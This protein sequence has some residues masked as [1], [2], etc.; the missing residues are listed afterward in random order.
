M[1]D[2]H[3]ETFRDGRRA[4]CWRAAAVHTATGRRLYQTWPYRTE[5]AACARARLWL[6][7]QYARADAG[8]PFAD[9]DAGDRKP[10]TGK[11]KEN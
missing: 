11:G 3:V 8:L 5:A 2:C 9:P 10:G 1:P 6:A 4:G 7:E